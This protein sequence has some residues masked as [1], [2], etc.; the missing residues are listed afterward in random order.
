VRTCPRW[1]H[2]G[3]ERGLRCGR[4]SFIALADQGV[5]SATNFATG[6]IIGRVCGKAELGVYALVWTLISLITEISAVLTTTPYTVFN[7]RLG[8]YQRSRYLGSVLAHQ[9]LLSLMFALIMAAGAALGSWRGW[10]PNDVSSAVSVT[11]GVIVFI[12]LREFVRRVSFAE[13][14]AGMALLVDTIACLVQAGGMLLLLHFGA[15]T[16]SRTYA[17]LGISSAL[18]AGGW[19]A[20]HW[21]AI[22]PGPRL[23]GRDWERNWR[24][25]KWVLGSCILSLFP[26][27]LFP[28][29][30]AAFHGTSAT[31]LWAACAAIV[32]LG[33]PVALGLGNHV[34]PKISKVYASSGA[35]AMQRQVHRST[36]QFA[37]LLIPLVLILMGW[38]EH[39]VTGVYGKAYAGSAGIV[40]LLALNTLISSLMYPYSQG[41]F[42]LER[43][44]ADTLVNVVTVVLLFTIGIAA[45]KSYAALGAAAALLGSSIITALIRVGVFAREIRRDRTT[46]PTTLRARRATI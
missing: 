30:L 38:G 22:R 44:K 11:A 16:V 29:V 8:Q 40:F 28:W 39:L 37:V 31:G 15:L 13:L 3:H 14:K 5:V 46:T 24:F 9:L 34:L 20:L 33:N 10:I 12:G 26:R 17:L 36:V 2:Y 41:L 4:G 19:L 42:S 35:A 6:V 43:A 27:Y 7:P 1:G 18:V 32:A 45:V 23:Y 21:R 25:A